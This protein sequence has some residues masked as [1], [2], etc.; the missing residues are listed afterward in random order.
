MEDGKPP[1]RT[2]G[3]IMYHRMIGEDETKYTTTQVAKKIRTLLSRCIVLF[4]I[5]LGAPYL[6]GVLTGENLGHLLGNNPVLYDTIQWSV[7]IMVI[8]MILGL[9]GV[10]RCTSD[11]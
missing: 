10:A 9:V 11:M 8:F 6:Y 4:C 2:G 3:R 7:I 1:A 5:L